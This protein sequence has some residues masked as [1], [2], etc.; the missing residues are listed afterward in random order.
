MITCLLLEPTVEATMDIVKQK[1][2]RNLILKTWER[3][4]SLGCS[5]GSGSGSSSNKRPSCVMITRKSKSWSSSPESH[6]NNNK[7]CQIAPEGCFSVYVGPQRQ[8]FVIKTEFANHPLF[9]ILLEDAE[10]EYGYENQ[11]PIMLPCDVDLFYKVLAEMESTGDEDDD[12]DIAKKGYCSPLILCS[13]P[14]RRTNHKISGKDCGAG[15]YRLLSPSRLL[16][17]NGF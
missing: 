3:C 7:R 4:K 15:A 2:K 9:K 11:G 16:K 14:T 6:N 13:S 10:S 17:M 5:S 8:R 1:W 12:H